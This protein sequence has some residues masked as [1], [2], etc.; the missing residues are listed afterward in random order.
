MTL[1]PLREAP[2][3]EQWAD[4][5]ADS[6]KRNIERN[7]KFWNSENSVRGYHAGVFITRGMNNVWIP[8]SRRMG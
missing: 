2:T 4:R 3:Y 8:A 7:R 6:R 5:Q 1:K